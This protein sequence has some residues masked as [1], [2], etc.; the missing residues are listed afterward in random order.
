MQFIENMAYLGFPPVGPD[1]LTEALL[2]LWFTEDVS[3]AYTASRHQSVSDANSPGLASDQ[4]VAHWPAL[5]PSAVIVAV[6]DEVFLQPGYGV[7]I[8]ALEND[9]GDGLTITSVSVRNPSDG[10]VSTNGT[11]ITYLT[12]EHFHYLECGGSTQIT[13]DYTIQDSVGRTAEG[14]ILVTIE[15]PLGVWLD[16]D[17]GVITD[18]DEAWIQF[19]LNT[20]L[21]WWLDEDEAALED[22]SGYHV[23]T[24]EAPS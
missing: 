15:R 4:G 11:T 16:E 5:A 21:L 9:I 2:G 10:E 6:T 19:C 8:F 13:L 23:L 18:E 17:G 3:P 1:R 24:L 22:E 20:P 12:D 14:V 7:E